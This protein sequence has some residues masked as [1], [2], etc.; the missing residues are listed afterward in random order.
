MYNA[1]QATPDTSPFVHLAARI[2]I[3]EKNDALAYGAEA[4]MRMNLADADL[5][6]ERELNEMLWR[7]IKG[8]K[9]VMPPAVR[10]AFVRRAGADA[11]DDDRR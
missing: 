1:L 2:S 5:A 6:P 3:D 4:S 9:A 8:P 7:S 10:A 11:D